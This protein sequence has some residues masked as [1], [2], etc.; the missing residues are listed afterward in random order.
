MQYTY[1]AIFTAEEE[2]GYSVNFPDIDG[3]WTCGDDYADAIFMAADAL[4]LVLRS[5]EL[6]EESIPP[7]T[8][9]HPLGER[10]ERVVISVIT[11][12]AQV[13]ITTAYAAEVLGVSAGRVRQL[14][15]N[16]QLPAKKRGRDYMV[17]YAAVKERVANPP[18]AGRVKAVAPA[19]EAK[20]A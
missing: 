12:E 5:A 14:V 15:A 11:D 2:G 8:F 18:K 6:D 3:C 19:Q 4:T 1:E 7:A 17:D 20:A 13:F 10:D 9:K 16:G